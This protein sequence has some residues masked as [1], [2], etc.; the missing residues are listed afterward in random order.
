MSYAALAST[1]RAFSVVDRR[2]SAG[3]LGLGAAAVVA[4]NGG[5]FPTSWGWAGAALAWAAVV[6]SAVGERWRPSRSELVFV[7]GLVAFAVWTALSILWTTT[8]SGTVFEVERMLVYVAGALAVLAIVR[9]AEVKWLVAGVA[10]GLWLACAYGLGTRLFPHSAFR[11]SFSGS[12][13]SS[14]VGYWN[15]LGL[16]AA[17]GALLAV[18]CATRSVSIA[19]RFLAGAALPVFLTTLYYTFS[20]GAWLSLLAGFVVFFALDRKRLQFLAASLLPLACAAIAVW[21]AS[22]QSALTHN[23]AASFQS[24]RDQGHSL[25]W[26]L[27]VLC[28][29]AGV[30]AVTARAADS[31]WESPAVVWLAR[32]V[33]A[34]AIVFAAAAVVVRFGSPTTIARHAYDSFNRGPTKSTNLN[35]RLFSLSNSG[36]LQAWKVAWQAFVHHPLAGLG[37]GGYAAYWN[38]HRTINRTLR[39]AHSVYL[40]TL[41]ETGIIGFALLVGTLLAPFAALRRARDNPFAVAAFAAYAAF[42]VEAAVDWDWELAGVTLAALLLGGAVLAA[43]RG[44][45]LSERWR[46]PVLGVGALVAV[47]A[48][49]GLAGNLL[50]SRSGSALAHGHL[51]A[52]ASDAH[53]ATAI[54]PWSATAWQHLGQ[55]DLA[56]GRH[57][58]AIASLRKAT[59]RDPQNAEWWIDLA[60][61]ATGAQRRAAL[62][63]AQQLNPRDASIV[64][65]RQQLGVK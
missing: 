3:A 41:A 16:V 61:A 7:C 28:L 29:A 22:R 13:L 32:A 59:M 23:A 33:L 40:E 43:A 39:D 46:W 8:Q 44:E 54:A 5:F 25:A 42:L 45:T 30:A 35:S 26:L 2:L 63:R 49:Y 48:M 11:D 62:D 17:M 65:I 21:R 60:L 31:L 4:A 15:G 10:V 9:E 14:P 18:V 50:V 58:Q 37:A 56:L 1:Q 53:R 47:L 27:I 51:A 38:E 64:A 52:A 24:A 20:R 19:W 57:S 12:R 55:A 34:V 6:G 36:R